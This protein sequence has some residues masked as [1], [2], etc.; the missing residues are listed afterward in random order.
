MWGNFV[1]LFTLNANRAAQG[2]PM[3]QILT[4]FILCF[5][6][7]PRLSIFAKMKDGKLYWINR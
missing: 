7:S 3:H 6:A 5:G 1:G 4:F 2:S